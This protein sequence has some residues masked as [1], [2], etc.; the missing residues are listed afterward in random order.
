MVNQP[1]DGTRAEKNFAA[2]KRLVGL[3][4]E[5]PKLKPI[6]LL[7]MDQRFYMPPHHREDIDRLELQLGGRDLIAAVFEEGHGCTTFHNYILKRTKADAPRRRVVPIPIILPPSYWKSPEDFLSGLD[8]EE[9]LLQGL[10]H[11]FV[12]HNWERVLARGQ[13]AE[14]ALGYAEEHKLKDVALVL[15]HVLYDAESKKKPIDWRYYSENG[16]RV[17]DSLALV[18][19]FRD[20]RLLPVLFFDTSNSATRKEFQIDDATI[21]NGEM[22]IIKFIKSLVDKNFIGKETASVAL[23]TTKSLFNRFRGASITYNWE[24][25]LLPRYTPSE[26]VAILNRHYNWAPF[27]HL[28][29][30]DNVDLSKLPLSAIFSQDFIFEAYADSKRTVGEIVGTVEQ[31]L[32]KAVDVEWRQVRFFLGLPKNVEIPRSAVEN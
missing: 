21:E 20:V 5:F 31:L 7:E 9:L 2:W 25:T 1:S 17:I 15:R 16:I 19:L 24:K 30:V 6:P 22:L 10:V 29:L 14:L 12:D 18:K 28:P 27:D 13:F 11:G 32:L 3:N 23:F 26:I 8:F 4:E